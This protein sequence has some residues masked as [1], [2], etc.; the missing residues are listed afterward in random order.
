MWNHFCVGF[1]LVFFL[2]YIL[3]CVHIL[4]KHSFLLYN[5]AFYSSCLHQLLE[6]VYPL[7][8]AAASGKHWK[9]ASGLCNLCDSLTN[10]AS[11]GALEERSLWFFTKDVS[12][13][14]CGLPQKVAGPAL[15][16]RPLPCACTSMPAGVQQLRSGTWSF[17][18][19]VSL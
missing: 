17:Y 1:G 15:C 7:H 13:C 18:K 9:L 5:R 6:C 8:K 10:K 4:V 3:Q 19:Q 12:W 14:S 16:F 11:H 2:R